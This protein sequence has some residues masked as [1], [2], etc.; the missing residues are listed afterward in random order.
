MWSATRGRRAA[1]SCAISAVTTRTLSMLK[2]YFS[3]WVSVP[4]GSTP[5]DSEE[6]SAQG[7]RECI[8]SSDSSAS[9]SQASRSRYSRDAQ[10]S[11]S[12]EANDGEWSFKYLSAAQ[13]STERWVSVVLLRCTRAW[14]PLPEMQLWPRVSDRMTIRSSEPTQALA[15]ADSIASSYLQ[16]K[17]RLRVRALTASRSA[18]R[19]CFMSSEVLTTISASRA[20]RQNRLTVRHQR[21][22]VW[23]QTATSDTGR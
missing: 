4:S 10:P 22:Q 1:A 23:P 6:G 18:P 2:P 16:R 11:S 13:S 17:V 12:R 5:K 19:T 14:R 8:M 9:D 20:S 21:L 15:T 3:I 7:L